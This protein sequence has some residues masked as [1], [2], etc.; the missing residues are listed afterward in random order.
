MA[1][2]KKRADGKW[3]ARYRDPEGKER[4]KHFARRV[5]AER[6][7]DSVRGDLVSGDYRDPHAG[8]IK[9]ATWADHWLDTVRPTLKPSTVENYASL[10]RSRVIPRFGRTPIN[11]ILPSDVQ[12][13]LGQLTGEGL[14]A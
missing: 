4:A 6:W 13:W 2:I 10:L 8:K 5:D 1:S 11:A 7:R 3:R 12:E 9:F 14:S